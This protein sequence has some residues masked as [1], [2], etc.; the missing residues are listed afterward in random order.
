MRDEN[1]INE[2]T[3]EMIPETYYAIADSIGIKNLIILSQTFGGSML[4]IPK[5]DS[6]T[7][8]IRDAKIKKEFNGVNYR[9]LALKYNLS[10]S[11]IR[12]IIN[13]DIINGQVTFF[14]DIK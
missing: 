3:K 2:I 10:E 4:Y 13:S 7:K 11:T 9:D 5:Y 6:L 8:S 12:N 1:W 14:N